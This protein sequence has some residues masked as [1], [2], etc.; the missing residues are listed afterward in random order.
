MAQPYGSAGEQVPVYKSNNTSGYGY[1]EYLP[2]NYVENSNEKYPLVFFFHGQGEQGNGEADLSKV[3]NGAAGSVPHLIHRGT[4]YPAMVISPQKYGG[5][6]VFTSQDFIILYDYIIEN[7]PVDIDRV[8]VTGLSAGGGSTWLALNSSYSDK[9][10]AAVPI[11]GNRRVANPSKHLQNTPIWLFHAYVDG[12]VGRN[13]SDANA[14]YIANT[15]SSVINYYPKV[16]NGVANTDITMQFD[17]VSQV[18]SDEVGIST[19]TQKLAYTIYKDGGH[20]IWSKTYNNTAVW[21]WMFAQSL[22]GVTTPPDPD[23]QPEPDS[24][25]NFL[26]ITATQYAGGR[27]INLFYDS[28]KTNHNQKAVG[29]PDNN[30][31][32][33]KIKHVSGALDY[34]RLQFIVVNKFESPT[35]CLSPSVV[36]QISEEWMTVTIPISEFNFSPSKL[37]PDMGVSKVVVKALSNFGSG[38]FALDEIMFSGG[39]NPFVW[40]G[41]DYLLSAEDGSIHVDAPNDFYLVRKSMGASARLATE[42]NF[43]TSSQSE[44]NLENIDQGEPLTLVIY[45]SNGKLLN[46]IVSVQ[47]EQIKDEISTLES[48]TLYF[49]KVLNTE[50]EIYTQRIFIIR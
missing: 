26:E 17:T 20:S 5:H 30:Q 49:I 6:G 3:I 36:S 22:S 44:L 35:V 9:I 39:N 15:G 21:N 37:T 45:N 40:Y 32:Q 2:E 41:E 46:R 25:N 18:W 19:P 12:L 43:F 27:A 16:N 24:V 7:Y 10:A 23:P 11:C 29:Y 47:Y 38:S 28:V 13:N 1:Y 4:D 48:N 31:F 34:N 8:Y 42:A 33:F 50:G 14:N